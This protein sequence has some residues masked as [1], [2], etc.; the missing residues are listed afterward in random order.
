MKS[1]ATMQRLLAG[2]TFLYIGIV[3]TLVSFGCSSRQMYY[4]GQ[5]WQQNQCNRM[6]DDSERQRCLIKSN[7]S[8]EDYKRQTEDGKK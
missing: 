5:A 2:R 4:T 3:M 1:T 6:I 7:M 8:Y